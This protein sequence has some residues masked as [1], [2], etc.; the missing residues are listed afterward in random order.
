M[1]TEINQLPTIEFTYQSYA[2]TPLIGSIEAPQ[3]IF[4]FFSLKLY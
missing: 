3:I 4:S 1:A 2:D